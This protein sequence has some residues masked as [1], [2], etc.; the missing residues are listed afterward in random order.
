MGSTSAMPLIDRNAKPAE[1]RTYS[2]DAQIE[3]V[4]A[5]SA[6]TDTIYMGFVASYARPREYEDGMVRLAAQQWPGI[7]GQAAREAK[8]RSIRP[9]S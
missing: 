7:V 4:I 8:A 9:T 5:G 3:L 1:G 2:D 6:P